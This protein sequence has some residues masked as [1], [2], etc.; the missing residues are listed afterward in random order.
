MFTRKLDLKSKLAE[1]SYFLFGARQTGKTTYLKTH[2]PDAKYI[3]LNQG[4]VHREYIHNPE[5][6]RLSLKPQEKIIVIDEIQRLP[7]LLNEVQVI[8]DEDKSRR[9]ILTGSSARSLRKKGVNLLGGRARTALMFP[10]IFP[11]AGAEYIN[12]RLHWGSLPHILTSSSPYDDLKSY[13]GTYLQEEI[14]AEGLVRSGE[15]FSRVLDVA[16][17]CDGNQLNY[18]EIANDTQVP[19]RTVREYFQLLEDT[20][21]AH[22]LPAYAKLKKRK[23]VSKP[24]FYLFDHGVA[25]FLKGIVA[26]EPALESLGS[27]LEH[28]IFLEISAYLSY[29][30]KDRKLSFFRTQNKEE[31]DFIIGDEVAVE[32]KAKE[33][34][35][36]RDFKNLQIALEEIPTL[37][38]RILVCNEKKWLKLDS[39]IEIFPVAEFLSELW[40]GSF[41]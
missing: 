30:F 7:T 9:F 24:K 32:V 31:V 22:T 13:I 20:L 14:R 6:L 17:L 28:L 36:S 10:L 29:S 2:F 4:D 16:G 39:G 5:R 40:A 15:S 3:N 12:Q 27:S 11:E 18:N 25:R 33:R 37:K 35:A 34:V 41:I 19:P 26:T 38:R 8:L 23:P 1:K 21:I